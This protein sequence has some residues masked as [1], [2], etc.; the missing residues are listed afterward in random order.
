MLPFLCD[1]EYGQSVQ[2]KQKDKIKVIVE[3]QKEV[4]STCGASCTYMG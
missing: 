4:G 3:Q 2:T 1:D